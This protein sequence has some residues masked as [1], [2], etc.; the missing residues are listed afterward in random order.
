MGKRWKL[1]EEKVVKRKLELRHLCDVS[2]SDVEEINILQF[3]VLN[4][5]IIIWTNAQK[6]WIIH[7]LLSLHDKSL[8]RWI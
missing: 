5:G 7:A 2:S 3:M 1:N 8:T 6:L 4:V